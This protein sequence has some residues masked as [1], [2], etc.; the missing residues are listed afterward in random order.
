LKVVGEKRYHSGAE[1]Q[2]RRAMIEKYLEKKKSQ[3]LS[4]YF[5]ILHSTLCGKNDKCRTA[6]DTFINNLNREK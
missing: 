1:Q 6:P 2:P 3:K 5:I 4:G